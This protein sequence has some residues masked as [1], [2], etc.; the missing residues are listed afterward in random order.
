MNT[1]LNI[2]GPSGSGKTT[3]ISW[4]IKNSALHLI[5]K[6][7]DWGKYSEEGIRNYSLS[8]MPV[9]AF[10]GTIKEYF[11]LFCI[12]TNDYE[13]WGDKIG[14]LLDTVRGRHSSIEQMEKVLFQELSAGEQRRLSIARALISSQVITIIDEPY[15]NSDKAVHCIIDRAMGTSDKLVIITHTPI[16]YQSLS[17]VKIM[18]VDIEDA[19]RDYDVHHEN[20]MKR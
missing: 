9:P 10:E 8:A 20:K 14:A 18:H 17:Q 6:D 4:L 19:K 5:F 7:V 16:D 1:I 12:K 3:F 13:D 2:Y 15:A 11:R